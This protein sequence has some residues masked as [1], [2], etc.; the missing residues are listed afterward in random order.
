MNFTLVSTVF[1]EAKRINQTIDDLENQVVRPSEIIIT[2]AGSNDGT[3]EL[4]LDWKK[5]SSITIIILQKNRCNVAEG[6]NM[7]IKAAS[8]NIIVSTD[9]GCRFDPNWFKSITD[10]FL[11]DAATMVTAGAYTV[12]ESEQ[13]TLPAKAAYIMADGYNANIHDD[14][15][16]PSSR[17]IAYKKEVFDKIG[18]YDESLTLAGD[19]MVFGLQIKA[20]GFK[21]DMI[22]DRYVK[23]GRHQ[24][25]S[26]FLKE[27]GRYG[28]G[29]G[30]GKVNTRIFIRFAIALVGQTFFAV[31]LLLSVLSLLFNFFNVIIFF[32]LIVSAIA[33]KSCLTIFK[34]WLKYRSS[35]Y[36]YG[37]LVYAFYMQYVLKISY[38]KNYVKGYLKA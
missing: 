13:V 31:F 25:L 2:D 35:K 8:Y 7:A 30:E 32:L 20:N 18:G 11:Q 9:F 27:V 19:D 1:N 14:K 4:L 26:A 33:L 3:Y 23:W 36:N 16:V 28:L 6:R 29:D 22:D 37:V 17:S 34:S 21:I 5:R 38:I 15:Y 10:P 24:K 12:D